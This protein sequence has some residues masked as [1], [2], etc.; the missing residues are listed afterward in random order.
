[1]G[2]AETGDAE[3]LQLVEQLRPLWPPV[4]AG[5]EARLLLRQ[6]KREEALRAF[7]TSLL[8][9]R[10]DPWPPPSFMLR[11]MNLA[12]ETARG[13]PAEMQRLFATL[14]VALRGPHDGRG[15][16]LR[17][18]RACQGHADRACLRPRLVVLRA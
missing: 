14:S 8:A 12:V 4:A 5:I 3:A 10:D 6:G 2:L 16:G 7:E 11:T 17:A 13:N 9:Y 15:A 18:G 1:M